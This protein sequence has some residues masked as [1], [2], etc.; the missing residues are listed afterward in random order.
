MLQ[1][2]E[3]ISSDDLV[4][5]GEES[6]LS[7]VTNWLNYDLEER[8]P[9]LYDVVQFVRQPL[10]S[11][12]SH[13]DYFL[14]LMNAIKDSPAGEQLRDAAYLNAIPSRRQDATASQTR[15]RTGSTT[16]IVCVGGCTNN[17]RIVI[18]TE[19]FDPVCPSW[20]S[21]EKAPFSDNVWDAR[22]ANLN[23]QYMFVCGGMTMHTQDMLADVHRYDVVR[24]LKWET[25]APMQLARCG[26]GA[27]VLNNHIYVFGG[28]RS[29]SSGSSDATIKRYDPPTNTW[30]Y[31][32]PLPAPLAFFASVA[33]NGHIYTFGGSSLEGVATYW[34]FRY[35][36]VAK[37]WSRLANMLTPRQN[38]SACV[39]PND[40]IYV[41]GGV[42]THGEILACVE[43]YDT[44]TD[45]WL[46]KRTACVDDKIYVLGGGFDELACYT[47]IEV[48]DENSDTWT[49]HP[50]QLPTARSHFGCVTLRVGNR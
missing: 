5:V 35:N 16:V 42:S 47:S 12:T 23:D 44:H 6:V 50:S 14:A 24:S 15:P 45:K 3:V 20:T 26:H 25:V 28:I 19:C 9:Q 11:V 7:A 10:L 22:L 33:Y 48:Y 13:P 32:E 1:I 39:G 4:V 37:Q 27:A 18:A 8:R 43:T 40:L 30:T 21:W 49:T 2:I 36:P 34:A 17:R 41:I 29:N 46:T 31:V 38:C